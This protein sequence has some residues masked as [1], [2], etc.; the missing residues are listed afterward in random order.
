MA[1]FSCAW[2]TLALSA[3]SL[4]GFSRAAT[5]QVDL[6][7]HRNAK[8]ASTG[9]ND[10]FADFDGSGRAYPVEYLPNDTTFVYQGIQVSFRSA[11]TSTTLG[12]LIILYLVCPAAISQCHC[13]RHS[14]VKLSGGSSPWQLWFP[15]LARAR[16]RC[17]GAHRVSAISTR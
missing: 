14:T 15:V 7:T 17:L 9:Y 11:Q 3:S 10:T 8:A 6:S 5:V 4:L 12:M 1:I 16:V 13:A 2:L